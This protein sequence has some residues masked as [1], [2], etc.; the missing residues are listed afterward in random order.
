MQTTTVNQQ[1]EIQDAATRIDALTKNLEKQQAEMEKM[2][3]H[4]TTVNHVL[5]LLDLTEE[6]AQIISEMILDYRERKMKREEV[7]AYEQEMEDKEELEQ[8]F[9]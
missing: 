8:E 4:Q 6:D 9:E 2:K 3:T 7:E 1:K 5:N